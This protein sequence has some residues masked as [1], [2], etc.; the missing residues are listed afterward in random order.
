MRRLRR[1]A[2]VV[3]GLVAAGVV[4]GAASGRLPIRPL[5]T[6]LQFKLSPGT[7]RLQHLVQLREPSTG[8]EVFLVGT[9]H[10]YHYEDDDWS[11]WHL[12][13]V[14]QHLHV[15]TLLIEMM[16]DAVNDGRVGEG[17]V[18]MPFFAT[19]GAELGLRVVGIDSGWDG[20]WQGRQDRMFQHVQAALAASPSSKRVIVASGMMHVRPFADQFT[21]AGYQV[22]PWS[23]A[24]RRAVSDD[25]DVEKAWPKGL[26]PALRSAIE[27]AR[28]GNL[29]TDP[30]RAADASWF[31]QIRE[32]ILTQMGEPLTSPK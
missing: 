15:D 13:A 3:L 29:D 23:E 11:I 8:R 16:A 12:K 9:T 14:V 6:F 10:Q 19:L 26:A 31:I 17:P 27:R 28:A 22:V 1:M 18:E 30:Q 7:A 25:A 32:Q 24:D 2:L 20:G 21:A 5:F 4:V